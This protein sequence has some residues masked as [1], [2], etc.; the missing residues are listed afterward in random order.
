M[1]GLSYMM[2]CTIF[3]NPKNGKLS[4]RREK[5]NGDCLAHVNNICVEFL[6]ADYSLMIS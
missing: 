1:D 4:C 6:A 5:F 3:R 2:N